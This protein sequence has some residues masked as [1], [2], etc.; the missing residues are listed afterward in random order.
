[1]E[2]KKEN[3]AQTP[4]NTQTQTQIPH[5]HANCHCHQQ[6]QNIVDF[7]NDEKGPRRQKLFAK[8]FFVPAIMLKI[9]SSY[10]L[11]IKYYCKDLRN[12]TDINYS[13]FAITIFALWLYISYQCFHLQPNQILTNIQI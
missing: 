6:T 1:M 10:V 2:A 13:R 8:I 11:Y 4:N 3:V 7:K 5:N 9:F 12:E